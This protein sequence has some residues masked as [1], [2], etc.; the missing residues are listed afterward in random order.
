MNY[1]D[2]FKKPS[3]IQGIPNIHMNRPIAPRAVSG[4]VGI[5]FEIEA[6]NSLPWDTGVINTGIVPDGTTGAVWIA[7]EDN[8][9]RGGVEYVTSSAISIDSVDPFMHGLYANIKTFKSNLRFTNRCSTHVH[10]NASSWRVNTLTAFVVIWSLL[11]TPLVE[12]CGPKRK[13]NHFCL[14]INDSTHTVDYVTSF[15]KTGMWTHRDGA[16]YSTLNLLRLFDIG[17]VEVRC[18]DA[19]QDPN[20]AVAWVRLLNQIKKYAE[21]IKDPSNIP[22]EISGITPLGLL[23][24]LTDKAGAGMIYDELTAKFSERDFN[25]MCY[26]T[27][28]ETIHLCYHPWGDWLPEIEKEYVKN[29]FGDKKKYSLR[30]FADEVIPVPQPPRPRAGRI[31]DEAAEIAERV[32]IEEMRRIPRGRDPLQEQGV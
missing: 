16:K 15:L 5:E 11:E 7:K 22:G 30:A 27:F 26:Q 25:R 29:P 6:T 31:Q 3:G 24:D 17:S 10:L 4:D 13:T 9:L 2:N 12:W 19:W 23:K 1:F 8:S 18:G 21:G 20:R 14:A 28:R 32:A